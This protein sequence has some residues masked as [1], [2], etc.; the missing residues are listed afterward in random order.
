M[1][2]FAWK[3]A[4]LSYTSEGSLNLHPHHH[5]YLQYLEL[6]SRVVRHSLKE[7]FRAAAIKRGEQGLKYGSWTNG[8]QTGT[9][10]DSRGKEQLISVSRAGQ[11][12]WQ[13]RA[14]QLIAQ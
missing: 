9:R 8:K 3:N 11:R 5:R 4:G 7:E 13:G 1:S 6:C 2:S 12:H 10:T 14:P